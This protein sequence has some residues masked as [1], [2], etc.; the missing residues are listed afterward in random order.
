MPIPQTGD[1]VLVNAA[2]SVQF[3]RKPMWFKVRTVNQKSLFSGW[4]WLEG[5]DIM[6]KTKRR[7]IYVDGTGLQIISVAEFS[8]LSA[9]A[10]DR[11]AVTATA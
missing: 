10:C 2:A 11:R 5:S 9:T 8:Q 7:W 3:A 1:V 6:R 4:L